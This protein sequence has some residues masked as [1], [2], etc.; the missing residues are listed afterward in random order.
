MERNY[1]TLIDQIEK[2][3]FSIRGQRV[4]LSSDLAFL[5]G[6]ETR[7]LNQAVK[8]N[9]TRFP[10]DFLFQITEGEAD[11]LV[12]Q[13]VIPHRK[14]LGGALPYAFTEQGVAM[15]SSVL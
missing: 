2:S 6:V 5:Y 8:R 11:M 1:V 9:I 14:Y 12:S 10:E 3:I 7:A 15:L 13:N 4:M